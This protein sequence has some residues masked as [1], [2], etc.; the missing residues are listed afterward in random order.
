MKKVKVKRVYAKEEFLD[1][2]MLYELHKIGE[3]I[4]KETKNLTD[5][6][7]VKYFKKGCK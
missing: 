1:D 3:R 5:E 6:E 7:W 2:E 4:Y